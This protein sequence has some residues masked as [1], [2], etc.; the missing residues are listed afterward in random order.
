MTNRERL[1]TLL[2]GEIP[3][4][5]PVC[6]DISNMVPARL[7]GKPF[8]DIYLYQDPPLWKA[9]IEAVKYYNIDGGF[10]LY[11][12][13]DLFNDELKS[14]Q[15]IVHKNEERIIT[16]DFYEDTGQWSK[17]V[18][19]HTKD[20]PPATDVLPSQVDLPETPNTWEDV[21]P[22]KKWPAG[23]DLWKMIKKEMGEYGIVGMPS[24]VETLILKRPEDIY[25]YYDNPDKYFVIREQM[26]EK[27]ENRLNNIASLKE[28]PD[29]LFCGA[30]G[31]LVFQSPEVFRELVLPA[32]KKV[33]KLAAEIGI[34]THVHSCGPEKELVKMAAEETGLSI[35]DPLET[36]P[37]GDCDLAELKKLYG[38]KI[39]LKGNL[40]TTKI[41]LYGTKEDV[42]RASQKAINDAGENGGFILST[43]DQCGRDTPDENI[44]TMVET[45]RTYGKY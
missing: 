33:T 12:F 40:H 16:Q 35:I 26:I 23:M 36:H 42:I 21:I 13:G 43:G 4:C 7:T 5:V 15:R 14:E 17:F 41:M 6:P 25:A 18:I 11:E 10:E 30:S 44:F 20:N 38:N 9:Y 45:A 32:L 39:I 29:F 24:G 34:P 37:M 2:K 3:D 31:S 19:V 22:A 27:M 28:K 1:L 8:W